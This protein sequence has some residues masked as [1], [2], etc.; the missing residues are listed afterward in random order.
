MSTLQNKLGANLLVEFR[1]LQLLGCRR[2]RAPPA[3]PGRKEF[4]V[5]KKKDRRRKRKRSSS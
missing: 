5:A 4:R 3:A 1:R 2:M